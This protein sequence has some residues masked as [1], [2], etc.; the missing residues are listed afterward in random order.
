MTVKDNGVGIPPEKLESIF[1]MFA[2]LNLAGHDSDG[3]GI[4]LGLARKFIE[5]HGGTI[6]AYSAGAKQG[7]EFVI[8]IPTYVQ[9]GVSGLDLSISA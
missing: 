8:W 9:V 1:D 7:S 5:M 2:Q 6:T 3:Q 4:G